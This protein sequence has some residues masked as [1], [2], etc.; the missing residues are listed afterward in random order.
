MGNS[1]GL[2]RRWSLLAR[3]RLLAPACIVLIA[4]MLAVLATHAASSEASSEH[5]MSSAAQQQPSLTANNI[6]TSGATLSLANHT[7]AWHYDR[8]APTPG[9]CSAEV[10]AGT[11]TATL[12]GLN[13]GT[14]YFYRAYTSST[15]S[16]SHIA[17]VT[18]TTAGVVLS[19]SKLIVPEEDTETYSVSLGSA[20]THTVTVTLTREST[21]DG[22]I[23]FDT[24][25]GTAG[26]QNIMTF[27]TSNWN[28]AQPV[29]VAAAN[30]ADKIYG[31]ST[32]THTATSTDPTYNN[33]KSTLDVS[34]GDNDVCQGTTAVNNATTGT[35]IDDCNTLLA[36]KATFAGDSTN[37]NWSTT[38]AI[39]E[40]TGVVYSD[41]NHVTRL[42][43]T[44]KGS[45]PNT[46]GDLAGLKHLRLS[47]TNLSGPIPP[48]LGNL[49]NLN[50]LSIFRTG[51]SGSIPPELGDLANLTSFRLVANS[52]LFGSI[53]PELGNLT[54]L[55]QLAIWWQDF[56]EPMPPELG[57]LT[58]LV[59]LQLVDATFPGTMPPELGNLS[60]LTDLTLSGADLSGTI[61][62]ELGKLSNLTTL[63]LNAN[64]LS[65][66][67]PAHL[68]NLANL[69]SLSIS[70]SG[71]SGTI[72]PE[73]SKLSNLTYL[74]LSYNSLSGSIP[75]ELGDLTSLL[76]LRLNNNS[77][78]GSI[79]S[80]LGNL[81]SLTDLFLHRN[82]LSGS[83]PSELGNLSLAHGSINF[84]NL[85]GCYPS[86]WQTVGVTQKDGVKLVV[87]DGI[88]ISPIHPSVPEGSTNSYS[89]V[90]TS[91]PTSPVT[92]ILTQ[93]GDTD[94]SADTDTGS[95]GIQ[96]N[97]IFNTDD[98][99]TSKDVQ[100]S[101]AQDDDNLNGTATITHRATSADPSYNNVTATLTATEL[102]D[103]TAL[104]ASKISHNRAALTLTSHTGVWWLKRI[105]PVDTTCKPIE[106][107][108]D[109][110]ILTNL[111]P[112]IGYI[113][114]A[115]S[116]NSCSTEIATVAFTTA[117]A[118]V[119]A[120]TLTRSDG[121]LIAAWPA[122]AGASG[123]HV[124]YSSD[125]GKTWILA[126]FDHPT[127][128]ITITGVSDSATYIVAVRARIGNDFG[129]WM[130][131]EPNEPPP[132]KPSSVSLIRG[133]GKL[134]AA[135]PAVSGAT[136]YHVTYTTDTD[137]VTK[138]WSLAAI[139][140]PTNS[141]TI[142]AVNSDPYIVGVRAHNSH[143]YSK[144]RNSPVSNA[145][146]PS[147]EPPGRPAPVTLTRGDGTLTATW[148]AVAGATSYH[149]TYTTDG[150]QSWSLAA[151]N[152]PTVAITFNAVN[153]DHYIVGVRA[154]NAHGDSK[155]RNSPTSGPYE[156]IDG[157]PEAP[158]EIRVERVCGQKFTV[159]FDHSVGA[160]GYDINYSTNGRKSWKRTVTSQYYNVWY[161]PNWNANKTYW[162][163]V[164]ALNH[165]G[166]SG[167]TNSAAAPPQPCAPSNLRTTGHADYTGS[168]GTNPAI[169]TSRITTAWNAGNLA[170]A[171]DV[172]HS[173]DNRAS[174]TRIATGHTT[175]THTGDTTGTGN[176]VV[177][178]RSTN[179]SL[180]SNWTNAHV[181][182]LTVN[183]ITATGATLNLSNHT[184]DWWL[185][186]TGPSQG[187][188]TPATGASHTLDSLTANNTYTY[189]AYNTAGCNDTHLIATAQSFTTPAQT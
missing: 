63:N 116:D 84:N 97:L 175:L 120:I 160:T 159:S 76:S 57:N 103:E 6:T 115:Y 59:Q 165:Q 153:S 19:A 18:F 146:T 117:A 53:P 118:P 161:F 67:I 12:T 16:D 125:G 80:E 69:S 178:V 108:D 52:N 15:C 132:S 179:G 138:T 25:R 127:N 182:W 68:A 26:N 126:A 173:P 157:P 144:W 105:I 185:K 155:W 136:G 134:T 79:P 13:P 45:I 24:D 130:N 183:N 149:V 44:G 106:D 95:P 150:G 171:Y 62:P 102:E 30:D 70:D 143:G 180:T 17:Q 135:W 164:R 123:Y 10:P 124:T 98:W 121:N 23:T 100:L 40:W 22:N 49:S 92:V 73:L 119:I 93:T 65:G 75:P 43:I 186:Q 131:S 162:F 158:A 1:E 163:A 51:A 36:A 167:W 147:A 128:S 88:R 11:S 133:D 46:F 32:I 27:T 56:S 129:D 172:N 94:I 20:P 112:S 37:L 81:T 83:V 35:L 50:Y 87:C 31:T 66:T 47:G 104:S 86:N 91:A 85:T 152:H 188:C 111:H 38:R 21:D 71:L 77:L 4:S 7:N 72:P 14:T 137:A 169:A 33:S 141:I 145:H 78:S 109:P 170:T 89:V 3:F 107:L 34:E 181:A 82:S 39:T 174:W 61:P 176:Y 2:N 41:D 5:P 139:S 168:T 54:N 189:N 96:N 177:A 42:I 140:H 184:G 58:N 64:S 166:H 8:I 156:H 99:A 48:Q 114:K 122:V 28:N 187:T 110:V 101:A 154:R 113:Y 55:T 74:D 151:I 9:T 90:L 29:T 142:D 60:N 148:P